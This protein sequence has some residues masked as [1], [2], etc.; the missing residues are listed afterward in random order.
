MLVAVVE[1]DGRVLLGAE[2]EFTYSAV[3]GLQKQSS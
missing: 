3:G 1:D 2:N